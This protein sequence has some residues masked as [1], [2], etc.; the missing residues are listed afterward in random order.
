MLVRI[1]I[2]MPRDAKPH[3]EHE[4]QERFM[5]SALHHK[6]SPRRSHRRPRKGAVLIL[7]ALMMI[8]LIVTVV[9]SVDIAVI[10]LSRTELRSAT[11]AASR[12]GT[13][14]LS[15]TQDVAAARAAAKAVAQSNKVNGKGLQLTDADIEFGRSD[16]PAGGDVVFTQGEEPFNTVRVTGRRTDGSPSGPVPLFF[17]KILGVSNFQ[18]TH[19]ASSMNLDRD[20]CLVVDRSGSMKFSLNNNRIAG[21]LGGCDPP[22]PTLS[23]W[24]ALNVAVGAFIEGLES[25]DQLEQLALASYASDNRS[26]G[27]DFSDAEVNQVLDFDYSNTVAQ[28]ANLSGIPINGFT[29][30]E[31]GIAAG[32]DALT[33]PEARPLAEKTMVL[34]TDGVFNRGAHPRFIAAT[35]AAQGITI[36]TVTFSAGAEQTAMQQVAAAAGGQHFHAPDAAALERI[37]RE[38]ASTL[39]VVMTE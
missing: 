2:R 3:N 33:G 22:H 36:H 28:M 8:V 13:E 37:F 12:A 35:A 18:P 10:Q 25:T 11:D 34:L 1:P 14:A 5:R 21:G 7:C 27:I 6:K 39:P 16:R 38:I 19:I 26:C 30:I 29:N 9:M 17:A 31:A 23:R 24:S 4:D 20:L 32:I 15:R